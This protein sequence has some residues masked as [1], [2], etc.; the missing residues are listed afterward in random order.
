MLAALS[1]HRTCVSV[2]LRASSA[3]FTRPNLTYGL[4]YCKMWDVTVTQQQIYQS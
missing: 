3:L 4:V 1:A 2:R